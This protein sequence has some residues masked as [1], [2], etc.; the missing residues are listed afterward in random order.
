MARHMTPDLGTVKADYVSK[1]GNEIA[2]FAL[3]VIS[4]FCVCSAQLLYKLGHIRL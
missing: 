3:Y 2:L 1:S 4:I